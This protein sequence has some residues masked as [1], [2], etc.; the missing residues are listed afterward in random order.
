MSLRNQVDDFY[1]CIRSFVLMTGQ[2]V[3]YDFT[4]FKINK[5]QNS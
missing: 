5:F 2:Q 1:E 3:S 4:I